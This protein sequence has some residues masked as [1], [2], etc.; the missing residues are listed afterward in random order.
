LKHAEPISETIGSLKKKINL[1]SMNED[2]FVHLVTDTLPSRPMNYKTIIDINKR[3]LAFDD[4]Q[5]P[6]LEAG[7]NSCAVSLEPK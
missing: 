5:M 4:M 6:D 7:P 1:L 3:M 2:E